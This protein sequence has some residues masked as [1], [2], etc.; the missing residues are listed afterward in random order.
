MKVIIKPDLVTTGVPNSETRRL[1]E[2]YSVV[3]SSLSYCPWDLA[4]SKKLYINTTAWTD[5]AYG[6]W[7]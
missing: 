2:P 1:P 7:V 6:K 4:Y 3:I 5:A